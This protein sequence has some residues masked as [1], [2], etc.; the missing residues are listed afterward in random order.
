MAWLELVG[1]LATGAVAGVLA[2]LLG[3]GGGAIIVPALIALF[4]AF[5]PDM[6]WIAQQAVATSLATIVLT[7]TAATLAHHRRGAVRWD[8]VRR[9]LP[10]LVLGAGLGAGLATLLPGL[11]LQRLFGVFLGY[12]GLRMI[13]PPALHAPP[14]APLKR[15]Q[16]QAG[17]AG[18]GVLSALLGVGGGILTVPFLVR[19]GVAMQA[20]VG[21]SSACG[22]PIALAGGLGFVVA[23]LGREGLA[24]A[25]IGFIY[26]PAALAIVFTSVPLAPVGAALA[27]RLPA[28]RLKRLFGALLML[29]AVKFVG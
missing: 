22:V 12:T 23:G 25:S 28:S 5:T 26:W 14:N 13:R 17:A 4:Y 16:L 21:S 10:S 9:M 18:I 8:L 27:H 2:G 3:V 7:G 19:C 29:I 20:A 11:W 6:E 24:A 1:Y 15:G